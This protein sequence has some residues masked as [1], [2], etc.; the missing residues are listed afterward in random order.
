MNTETNRDCRVAKAR[1]MLGLVALSA[2]LAAA[3]MMALLLTFAAPLTV[4]A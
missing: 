3:L 1:G 2:L 4:G